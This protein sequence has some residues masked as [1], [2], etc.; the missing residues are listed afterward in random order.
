MHSLP[1]PR[2]PRPGFT[3]IELL[4]VIAIIAVLIGMLLPAVQKVRE[5]AARIH[6]GSNLKQMGIACQNHHD[7]V[8]TLPSGGTTWNMAPTYTAP[9]KPAIGYLQQ[10][11]PFFQL[12]P[13]IEQD[14]VYKG[15]GATTIAQCQIVAISSPIKTYFCPSRRSPTVL[16]PINN[17][18]S[19]G[20][21]GT[22]GHGAMDYAASNLDNTGVIVYGYNGRRMTDIADGSSNTLLISEKRLDRVNLNS[23]QSD[24]NEGYS[25][26]WDHDTIRLTSIAP[27]PDSRTGGYGELRFGS[28]HPNYFMTLMADGSVRS[29][30][31]TIDQAVFTAIGTIAGNESVGV[32]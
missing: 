27:L 32:P 7:T 23:Y 12:L 19:A 5:A 25:S 15:G 26:G 10:G 28:S 16:P 17:W 13:Y 22:F 21:F 18:Y 6:C 1:K 20:P 8:G 30:N 31:Y 11:G 29:L 9:G 2:K 24:D 3:L 14:N 4:V